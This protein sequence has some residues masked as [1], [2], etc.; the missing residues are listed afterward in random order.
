VKILLIGN[1]GRE[2]ALAWKL[3]QSDRVRQI[4]CIPGNGGTATL[5]RCQ[6]MALSLSDFEGIARFGLVNGAS[7]AVIGP[8]APL[9]GGLA[10][11][12]N[13]K[14][15][16]TFGPTRN[17][18]QIESS[19]SWAKELMRSAGVP[20]AEGKTFTKSQR[21]EARAYAAMAR[22]P[23]VVKAD[24]LAAGKG[25]IVADTLEQAHQAIDV[26]FQGRFGQA[27]NSIVIEEFLSGQEVSLLALTDGKTVRPLV[28]SQDHKPIGEG[29]TGPNTGG[30]GAY[31]PTPIL[32]P[33][34]VDGVVSRILEPV[35]GALRDRGIDYRGVLYAGLMVSPEG[36]AKV[37]EFNCRF[38]DPETQ[39][40]LP[41]LETPLHELIEACVQG[42]LADVT[43]ILW[44]PGAAACVVMA[45]GGYPEAYEKGKVITGIDA[46]E[47]M[48]AI[49]FHAGTQRRGNEL[50]TSGGRVLGVTGIGETF[51][52]AIAKAY[53]AIEAIEFENSYYRHDIGYR[54]KSMSNEQ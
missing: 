24:G 36:D 43:E 3:L 21:G 46:A 16:P 23:I 6:N 22:T 27:G 20:T 39:A 40:V 9:A 47:E 38:G 15:I 1:G 54:V 51:S 7:L 35:V 12:L 34:L 42:C 53:A 45:A 19:K 8:E 30:M 48:G 37:L 28:P 33:H 31:A 29:D 14:N 26:L 17:G 13:S 49:V 4:F 25:V 41:L 32:P 2:H 44:K 10:D 50:L 52:G 11:F 5:E 18:A